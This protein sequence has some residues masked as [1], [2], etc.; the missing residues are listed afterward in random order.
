MFLFRVGWKFLGLLLPCLDKILHL[1]YLLL[2]QSLVDQ[3]VYALWLV[4]LLVGWIPL[5]IF[6]LRCG[7]FGVFECL[8]EKV[9]YIVEGY[10]M[11]Y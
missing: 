1:V 4:A 11:A 2:Y 7:G 5:R 3:C 6:P 10:Y 9:M 8:V